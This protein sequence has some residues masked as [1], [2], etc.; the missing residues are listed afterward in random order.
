MTRRTWTADDCLNNLNE[1]QQ[2]KTRNKR[3][4]DELIHFWE[5]RLNERLNLNLTQELRDKIGV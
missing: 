1:L 3:A 4:L 2:T 5:A